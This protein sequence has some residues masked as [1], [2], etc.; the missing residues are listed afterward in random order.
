M[1]LLEPTVTLVSAAE[2]DQI[3]RSVRTWLNTYTGKPC[4]VDF[5]YL[6]ECEGLALST[7]QAAYKTAQYIDGSY[8]AQY[9]FAL[10]YRSIP[11]TTEERIAMDEALNAYG[12]WAED[13][14]GLTLTG[15]QQAL[16]VTRNTPSALS[17]RYENGVEDHQILLTLLYEVS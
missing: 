9:Q 6:G 17:F 14:T 15:T 7:V 10:I 5:E 1:A 3:A 2:R 13:M 11:S 12:A 16:K 4:A 8:Q